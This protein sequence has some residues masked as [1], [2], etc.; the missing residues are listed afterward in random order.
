MSFLD[1]ISKRVLDAL[2]RRM[3]KEEKVEVVQTLRPKWYPRKS[4][5][6]R[7]KQYQAAIKY[8]RRLVL[9]N[10]EAVLQR[11]PVA[12]NPYDP[13]LISLSQRR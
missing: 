9:K 2:R 13:A 5:W 12:V 1:R 4:I 8:E 6:V 3:G 11:K 7:G 10:G